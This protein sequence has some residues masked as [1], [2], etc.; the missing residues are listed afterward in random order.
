MFDT[1]NV[2]DRGRDEHEIEPVGT[3]DVDDDD[4]EYRETA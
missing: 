4:Q 2:E 1:T 3:A